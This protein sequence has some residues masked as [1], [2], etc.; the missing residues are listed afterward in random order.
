MRS[1]LNH[2]LSRRSR[3]HLLVDSINLHKI[4]R[5]NLLNRLWPLNYLC[6]HNRLN[7]LWPLNHQCKS[8]R[9]DRLWPHNYQFNHSRSLM[10]TWE[11]WAE[12]LTS[13][14]GHRSLT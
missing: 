4:L 14:V 6:N 13:L 12:N 10:S 5:L 8:N 2:L 1:L 9:L 11:R 7:R 3:R